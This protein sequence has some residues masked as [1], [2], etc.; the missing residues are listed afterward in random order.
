[1]SRTLKFK[2][3]QTLARA[4]KKHVKAIQENGVPWDDSER[5]TLLGRHCDLH[6]LVWDARSDEANREEVFEI[7]RAMSDAWHN[8]TTLVTSN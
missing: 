4:A 2:T 1:M 6:K 8:A 3:F 7:I 5:M